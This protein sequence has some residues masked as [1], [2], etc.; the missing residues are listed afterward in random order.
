MR[1]ETSEGQ[2]QGQKNRVWQKS[3]LR[4]KRG[5]SE[6][7]DQERQLILCSIGRTDA[8][9]PEGSERPKQPFAIIP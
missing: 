3:Q 5:E 7:W 4:A 1:Y 6:A 8:K 2:S 9:P